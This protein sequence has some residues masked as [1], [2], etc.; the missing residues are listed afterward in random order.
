MVIQTHLHLNDYKAW[1]VWLQQSGRASFRKSSTKWWLLAMG[2]AISIALAY[3]DKTVILPIHWPTAIVSFGFAFFLSFVPFYVLMLRTYKSLT[4]DLDDPVLSPHNITL[5]EN[6]VRDQYHGRDIF[7][8]WEGIREFSETPRHFFLRLDK[9][10]AIIIPKRDCSDSDL[11]AL[12][13]KA[14]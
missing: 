9:R 6:G 14:T 11:N 4:P 5:E 12:R 13:E 7:I 2:V 8:P 3:N 1:E 10:T